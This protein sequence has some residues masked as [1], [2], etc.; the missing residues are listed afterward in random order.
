MGIA[1]ALDG[2]VFLAPCGGSPSTATR[3]CTPLAGCDNGSGGG[4]GP[5]FSGLILDETA[6]IAGEAGSLYAITL[7][8]QGLVESKTYTGGRDQDSS[9]N[10]IPADGF[11][12]GPWS[13]GSSGNAYSVY[14]IGTRTVP[15]TVDYYLNSIGTPAD[16]RIRH[17]VFPTD[18][19]GTIIVEGGTS[20]R[21][22]LADPNCSMIRN[23][24][25]PDQSS[26]CRPNTFEG[27]DPV[28]AAKVGAQPYSGQF[29]GMRVTNVSLAP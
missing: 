7:H 12:F 28:I 1:K 5:A 16:T 2:F 15:L 13:P 26:E 3:T 10:Q 8:F 29:L 14:R 25:E 4:T 17:S 6:A 24:S 22:T 23:C 19:S 18:Y 27:L 9:G 11:Y 20:V 21:L